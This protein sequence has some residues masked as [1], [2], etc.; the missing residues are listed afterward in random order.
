[1]K[2]NNIK[3]IPRHLTFWELLKTVILIIICLTVLKIS[4]DAELIALTLN[5]AEVEFINEN[6]YVEN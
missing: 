3:I 6:N 4:K 5:G 2:R 1:M